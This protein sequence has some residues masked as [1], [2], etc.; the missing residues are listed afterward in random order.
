MEPSASLLAE[1]DAVS[2]Q[3][4]AAFMGTSCLGPAQ[5]GSH[6]QQD[7]HQPSTSEHH[8][9]PCPWVRCWWLWSCCMYEPMHTTSKEMVSTQV[10]LHR[11]HTRLI[12]HTNRALPKIP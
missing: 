11:W 3:M 12:S 4:S 9:H 10:P 6:A 5:A 8:W 7:Q 1:L 2:N